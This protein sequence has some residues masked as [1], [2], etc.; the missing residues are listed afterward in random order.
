MNIN[1]VKKS[2]SERR[3]NIKFNNSSIKDST[4]G[5]SATIER[6]IQRY[7]LYYKGRSLPLPKNDKK[8]IQFW[9]SQNVTIPSYKR[10]LLEDG[11]I[12][13]PYTFMKKRGRTLKQL[14]EKKEILHNKRIEMFK[15]C[16]QKSRIES[17]AIEM[18]INYLYKICPNE[19]ESYEFMSIY[20]CLYADLA[21]RH[22]KWPKNK[23]K[24]FQFKTGQ[25]QSGRTIIYQIGG[26]DNDIYIICLGIDNYI[27]KK[28][29][30]SPDDVDECDLVSIY[31]VG[32]TDKKSF[33]PTLYLQTCKYNINTIYTKY[34]KL[35][36]QIS[37]IIQFL[38]DLEEDNY[39]L[40]TRQQIMFEYR[41]SPPHKK[42]KLGIKAIED[43]LKLF[44]FSFYAPFCQNETV[45]TII[46]HPRFNGKTYNISNKTTCRRNE[47][48]GHFSLSNPSYDYL[49]DLVFSIYESDKSSEDN[50]IF[51]RL[52]II[53]GKRVYCKNKTRFC[54]SYKHKENKDIFENYTFFLNE[55]E[56][57]A[58]KIFEMLE[59][60]YVIKRKLKIKIKINNKSK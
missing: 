45:D 6:A 59:I 35:N 58:N 52:S 44:G 37:S 11:T 8:Q 22:K 13:D 47:N 15:G 39:L 50:M 10:L 60:N 43:C 21:I 42:E 2:S 12:S 56:K 46:S 20:D 53:D 49:V 1:I 48:E 9:D 5:K 28:E 51:D 55:P 54:W 36:D 27:P 40:L 29:R 34:T 33:C 3:K 32:T 25:V 17:A 31:F 18:F 23:Y 57:I 14:Q 7:N 38:N 24:M 41:M 4:R 26:Y 30:I 19:M 16:L